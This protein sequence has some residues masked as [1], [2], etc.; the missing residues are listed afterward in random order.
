M[1][2]NRDP[3]D[4][5]PRLDMDDV[6]RSCLPTGKAKRTSQHY[7]AAAALLR[8]KR[9]GHAARDKRLV[10]PSDRGR[11]EG[12]SRPGPRW[13]HRIGPQ[14]AGVGHSIATPSG[15]ARKK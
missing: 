13:R 1:K 8:R 4:F 11:G 12:R 10:L 9:R 5:W 7:A 15:A 2:K 6:L 14:L 3:S